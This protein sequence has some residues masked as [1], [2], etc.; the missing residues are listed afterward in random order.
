MTRDEA[1]FLVSFDRYEKT[2]MLAI[3]Y[4]AVALAVRTVSE[5]D[6][7]RIPQAAATAALSAAL[8][9]LACRYG[10]AW[11]PLNYRPYRIGEYDGLEVRTWMETLKAEYDIPDLPGD[12]TFYAFLIEGWDSD[13]FYYMG[14]Y[15][16][17][18][19]D[20]TVYENADQE[21]LNRTNAKYVLIHDRENP[22]IRQW[23]QE[24]AQDQAGNDVIQLR[25]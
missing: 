2:V 16:F 12:G 21:T 10:D 6:R 7:I 25:E 3:A 1:F 24:H 18:G 15:V 23:V 14:T 9:L 20:I 11:S 5:T 19:T 17:S 8:C 22:I 4:L 13:Y